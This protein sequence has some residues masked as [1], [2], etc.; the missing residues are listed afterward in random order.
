[1]DHTAKRM[2]NCPEPI[3]KSSWLLVQRRGE[4][5][6]EKMLTVYSFLCSCMVVLCTLLTTHLDLNRGARS[7]SLILAKLVQSCTTWSGCDLGFLAAESCGIEQGT[8]GYKLRNPLCLQKNMQGSRS[9][10]KD[11]CLWICMH[12]GG[13]I[14]G[15]INSSVH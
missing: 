9:E 7:P 12:T 5:I 1:M 3:D 15:T 11:T 6:A 14:L 4:W 13:P 2:P 8:Q 10:T